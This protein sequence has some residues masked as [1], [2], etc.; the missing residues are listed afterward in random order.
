MMIIRASLP[1][2]SSVLLAVAGSL[3]AAAPARASCGLEGCPRVEATA[4]A[5]GARPGPLRLDVRLEHTAFDLT[6]ATGA[7]TA[8]TPRVRYVVGERLAA[9]G[10]VPLITLD[11]DRAPRTS[12]LGN[13][14]AFAEV[15]IAGRARGDLRVG[16]QLELPIGD[17][18]AGLAD[19]HTELLPYVSL[20]ASASAW[21]FFGTLGFREAL[22]SGTSDASPTS[23]ARSP[24]SYARHDGHDHAGEP[25]TVLVVNPHGDT[26]LLY[27]A[28][29]AR[30]L[31]AL[32]TGVFVDGQE[33]LDEGADVSTFVS[34]GVS[35]DV[36]LHRHY[37]WRASVEMPFTRDPRYDFRG[38]TA[39]HAA[40]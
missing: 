24:G 29:I 2:L 4:A 32:E 28:G 11:R 14:V 8:L 13:A 38:G 37:T 40:F 7:Y 9:G 3:L 20:D 27:R 17:T 26:E 23:T 35:L 31:G 12:G 16:A 33:L 6:G 1:D 39:I 22:A 5:E 34:G 30:R 36:R 19:D 15:R 18:D 10:W 25:G 21:R